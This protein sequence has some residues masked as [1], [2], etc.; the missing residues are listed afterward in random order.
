MFLAACAMALAIIGLL[1]QEQ[2]QPALVGFSVGTG[3][4]LMAWL[5]WI[6]LII[7]GAIILFAIITNLDSILPS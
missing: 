2:F 4:L 1:R 3:V 6:A 5:Q 7:C